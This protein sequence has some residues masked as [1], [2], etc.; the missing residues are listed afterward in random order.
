MSDDDLKNL[1]VRVVDLEDTSALLEYCSSCGFVRRK[2]PMNPLTECK[3]CG[4][5]A[6][7]FKE[8]EDD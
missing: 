1:R 7:L 2:T 4:A 6:I 5:S 8:L 3:V